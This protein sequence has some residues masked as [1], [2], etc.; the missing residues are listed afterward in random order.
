VKR[1]RKNCKIMK[2]STVKFQELAN[3][4][5]LSNEEQKMILGG[6]SG[7]TCC[8]Y[9]TGTGGSASYHCTSSASVAEENASGTYG[10]WACGTYEAK[11]L[12][13]C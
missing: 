10:T 6:Y 1:N 7:S 9:V 5:V 13:A 11:Q 4:Q 2:L 12:C 3:S 8:F